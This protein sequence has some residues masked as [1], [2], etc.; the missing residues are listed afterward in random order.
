MEYGNLPFRRLEF[1]IHE[2][3]DEQISA[4]AEELARFLE[5][6]GVETVRYECTEGSANISVRKIPSA[7]EEGISAEW[8][9]HWEGLGCPIDITFASGDA[10]YEFCHHEGVHIYGDDEEAL[11]PFWSRWLAWGYT[12]SRMEGGNCVDPW[13]PAR[14]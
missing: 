2:L 12:V 9:T 10:E 11:K 13:T 5:A 14:E 7:L 1:S 4:E 6:V 3:T 8:L